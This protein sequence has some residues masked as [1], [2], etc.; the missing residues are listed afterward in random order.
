MRLGIRKRDIE[1]LE[2]R[3]QFLERR[4]SEATKDLTYDRAEAGALRRLLDFV[5]AITKKGKER[6]E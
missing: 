6:D 3:W 4:T 5:Q 2:R 1:I